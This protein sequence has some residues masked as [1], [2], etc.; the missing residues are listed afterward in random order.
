MIGTDEIQ[1]LTG[2]YAEPYL[3]RIRGATGRCSVTLQGS[4]VGAEV[5]ARRHTRANVGQL[6]R[7]EDF[8]HVVLVAREGDVLGE[9]ADGCGE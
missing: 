9:A 6:V 4:S 3:R 5:E 2:E 7:E 1:R 8:G